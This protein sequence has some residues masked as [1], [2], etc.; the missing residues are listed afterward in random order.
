MTDR[1]AYRTGAD[2]ADPREVARQLI[3]HLGPTL[4]AATAGANRVGDAIEW[5]RWDGPMPPD[6]VARRLELAHRAWTEVA[7]AEGDDV[8]RAFFVGGNPL[9]GEDTPVTA[10]REGRA[11]EVMAAVRALTEGRSDA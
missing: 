3:S 8:A 10:V 5:A 7:S 11:T 9:L 6:D 2:A 1:P 4:V